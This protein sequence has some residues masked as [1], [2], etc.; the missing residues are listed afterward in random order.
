M[1]GLLV[2]ASRNTLRAKTLG[3]LPAKPAY[4]ERVAHYSD[5]LLGAM[6]PCRMSHG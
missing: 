2:G 4:Q 1:N 3:F 6:R 5:T